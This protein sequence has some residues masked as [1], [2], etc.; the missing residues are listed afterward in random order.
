MPPQT[1]SQNP[2]LTIQVGQCFFIDTFEI[3]VLSYLGQLSDKVWFFKVR[4][5]YSGENDFSEDTGLLR[6]GELDSSLSQEVNI[7]EALENYQMIAPLLVYKQQD[8][9]VLTSPMSTASS[10]DDHVFDNLGILDTASS[11]ETSESTC[12]FTSNKNLSKVEEPSSAV[13]ALK[14]QIQSPELS[15]LENF[16]PI[17]SSPESLKPIASGPEFSDPKISSKANIEQPER[18]HYSY[19]ENS[20]FYVTADDIKT[21]VDQL[22][23]DRKLPL[24]EIENESK[25]ESTGSVHSDREYLEEEEYPVEDTV[26]DTLNQKLI[27]LSLYPEDCGTLDDWFKNQHSLDENLSIIIQICQFFRHIYQRGWCFIHLSPQLIEISKPIKFYDL[28]GAYAIDQYLDSGLQGPYC[29]PELCYKKVPV[30]ESLSSYAI[31]ALLYQLLYNRPYFPEQSEKC[32]LEPIPRVYQLLRICLSCTPEERFSLTQ[33]IE[34]LMKTRQILRLGGITWEIAHRSTVG[35]SLTRLQNED[36]YGVKQHQL[37]NSTTLM[38]GVLAD[39]MGGMAGGDIASKL[40][41]QTF[42]KAHVPEELNSDFDQATWL[43]ELFQK[44]NDE[45]AETVR[46]GGSTLSV[47][48]VIN[49]TLTLAHVGDSRIYLLRKGRICQLSEDHSLVS[50]LIASGE[51]TPQE[52]LEHPERNVLTKSLGSNRKLANGYIQTLKHWGGN[53]SISLQDGDTLL[54]CSDGVWDLIKDGDLLDMFGEQS[55]LQP[56]VNSV[57]D[58]VLKRGAS[59]NATLLALKLNHRKTTPD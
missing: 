46:D 11:P 32:I 14:T 12:N 37:G 15:R 50:M 44:A 48:L 26:I 52:G 41:V 28:T 40:A 43:D 22:L 23:D 39:G 54:L 38:L 3:N 1:I 7:R 6:V 36:S 55:A 19:Q 29:A 8:A 34:L 56:S 27:L 4:F 2:P 33:L 42:L 45:I 58:T 25:G 24:S 51:I 20:E 17:E 13:K 59:D 30:N 10:L 5:K 47:V 35:L 21:S 16:E 49:K 57:I 18:D 31:G 9:V 53:I